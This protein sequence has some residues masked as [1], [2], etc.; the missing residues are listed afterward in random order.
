MVGKKTEI[1]NV[2]E[3]LDTKELQCNQL[4]SIVKISACA[5][6]EPSI[7]KIGVDQTKILRNKHS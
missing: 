7:S 4:V 1:I 3:T 5:L 2:T 6:G